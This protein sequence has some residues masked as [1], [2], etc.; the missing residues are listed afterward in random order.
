MSI[1][2]FDQYQYE[3]DNDKKLTWLTYL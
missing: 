3:Y 1:S 2:L